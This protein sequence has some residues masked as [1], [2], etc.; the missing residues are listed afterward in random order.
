VAHYCLP[1]SFTSIMY[2]LVLL[3]ALLKAAVEKKALAAGNSECIFELI[4]ENW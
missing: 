4:E 3:S 1:S 2:C